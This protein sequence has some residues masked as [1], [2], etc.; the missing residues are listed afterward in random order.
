LRPRTY[1]ITSDLA[2]ELWHSAAIHHRWL[3]RVTLTSSAVIDSPYARTSG[4]LKTWRFDVGAHVR[5]G[6][7]LAEIDTPGVDFQLRQARADLS[8]AL[9]NLE[10]A[11]NA[12][13]RNE[14]L[15]KTRSVSEQ[16]RDKANRV[17]ATDTAIVQSSEGNVTRLEQLQSYEKVYAPF[18][19]IITSR[20]ADIEVGVTSHTTP[21]VSVRRGGFDNLMGRSRYQGAHLRWRSDGRVS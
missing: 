7:L 6:D 17:L 3:P 10:L 12:A 18:D 16:D 13:E 2:A 9:S 5:K 15:L 11:A 20:N 1:W 19:G 8:S 14:N 21:L 4:Y